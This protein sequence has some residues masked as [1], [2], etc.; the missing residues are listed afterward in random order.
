MK[1]IK[2]FEN[3]HTYKINDYVLIKKGILIGGDYS[4][5]KIVALYQEPD[6]YD[7]EFTDGWITD[8]PGRHISRLLTSDEIEQYEAEKNAKKYN[9]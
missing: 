4:L 9:I 3:K 8:M 6:Y 5:G 2:K 1:Y 7:I